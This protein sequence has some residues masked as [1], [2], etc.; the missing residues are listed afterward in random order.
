MEKCKGVGTRLSASKSSGVHVVARS[1]QGSLNL[2]KGCLG[3]HSPRVSWT[4]TGWESELVAPKSMGSGTHRPHPET[5][6][7][8]HRLQVVLEHLSGLLLA[9]H[10]LHA[11]PFQVALLGLLEDLVGAALPGPQEL[12]RLTRPQQ[13]SCRKKG[14]QSTCTHSGLER[15]GS[16]MPGTRMS[17]CL[18]CSGSVMP[19]AQRSGARMPG[20]LGYPASGCS[21]G[22]QAWS[23]TPRGGGFG[24]PRGTHCAKTRRPTGAA[25]AQCPGRRRARAVAAWRGRGRGARQPGACGQSTR[26]AEARRGRRGTR[27]PVILAKRR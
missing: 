20:C 24:G 13:H 18:G 2:Q 11:L 17:V 8:A 12:R 15:L 26:E 23:P 9:A 22:V 1:T 21:A 3:F 14:V 27:A 6:A 7:L 10:L 19:R 4:C 25:E 5:L 16:G